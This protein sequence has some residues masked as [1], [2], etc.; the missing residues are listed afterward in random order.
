[1]PLNET[2]IDTK[3]HLIHYLH[4]RSNFSRR[5]DSIFISDQVSSY[6]ASDYLEVGL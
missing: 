1:M 3:N 2:R 6:L 4:N 5:L